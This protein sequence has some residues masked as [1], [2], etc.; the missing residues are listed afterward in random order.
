MQ[1]L[2]TEEEMIVALQGKSVFPNDV[3]V[4]RNWYNTA[5]ASKLQEIRDGSFATS[6]ISRMSLWQKEYS[7]RFQLLT[8]PLSG[9]LTFDAKPFSSVVNKMYREAILATQPREITFS[10]CFASFDDL[11]RIT[12]ASP[13]GDGPKFLVKKLLDLADELQISRKSSERANDYGY[14]AIHFTFD[15]RVE[16]LEFAQARIA[17]VDLT[18]EIQLTTQLQLSLRTLTHKLYEVRR[19]KTE[20][21]KEWKW[22][23]NS[24]LF[25][26]SYTGHTLHLLESL[27]LEMKDAEERADGT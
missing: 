15:T 10:D 1:R 26:P 27:L 12:L 13:Y 20:A 22:D 11:V 7:N 19:L 17:E 16:L 4:A 6:V 3:R 23:F 5:V 8:E 2:P 14:Y 21:D 24:E 18:A 9:E 25:R